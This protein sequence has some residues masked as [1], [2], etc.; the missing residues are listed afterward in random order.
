MIPAFIL[1]YYFHIFSV[2]ILSSKHRKVLGHYTAYLSVYCVLHF[3]LTMKDHTILDVTRR[4][5]WLYVCWRKS[6][7]SLV[8]VMI[9]SPVRRMFLCSQLI[10]VTADVVCKYTCIDNIVMLVFV[11]RQT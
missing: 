11:N 3:V 1:S 9:K 4:P 5:S 7:F 8:D 10:K 2:I 6:F